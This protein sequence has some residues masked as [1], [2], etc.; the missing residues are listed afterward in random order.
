MNQRATKTKYICPK[1]KKL[2][3]VRESLNHSTGLPDP[4]FCPCVPRFSW[5][6]G[7][8]YPG[9]IQLVPVD[10]YVLMG[11][12]AAFWMMNRGLR[13]DGTKRTE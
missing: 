7:R 11:R 3:D 2:Y 9:T 1:C 5:L 12:A 13:L 4:E 8:N 6:E 10:D